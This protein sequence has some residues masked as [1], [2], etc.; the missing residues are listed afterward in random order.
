[1]YTG[2]KKRKSQKENKKLRTQWT[3]KPKSKVKNK[4]SMAAPQALSFYRFLK[5]Q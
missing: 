5:M 3:H 4:V 2:E 1:M